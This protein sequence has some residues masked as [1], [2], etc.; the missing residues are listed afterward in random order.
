MGAHRLEPLSEERDV[1]DTVHEAHVRHG[2]DE[3]ARIGDCSSLHQIRPKL[4]RQVELYINLQ[5][6]RNV[7]AAVRPLWRVVHLAIR[8]VTGPSVVPGFRAFEA[9]IVKGLEHRDV[10]RG[11]EFLKEDPQRG[12]HNAGADED[13]VWFGN[14]VI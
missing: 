10:E 11:L 4:A 8:G 7:D 5:R 13:D 12:A 1:A 6:L 14:E 9:T 3:G 2:M